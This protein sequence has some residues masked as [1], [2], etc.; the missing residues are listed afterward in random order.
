MKKFLTNLKNI[1]VIKEKKTKNLSI[2]TLLYLKAIINYLS[3]P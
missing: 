1:N 3:M 2:L